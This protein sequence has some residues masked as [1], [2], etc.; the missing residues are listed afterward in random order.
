MQRRIATDDVAGILRRLGAQRYP[1]G[2]VALG[3]TEGRQIKSL[4]TEGEEDV[5]T[6][7]FLTD[8]DDQID[9][10]RVMN[11]QL[12]VFIDDHQ[13]NR[14]RLQVPARQP[15]LLILVGIARAGIFEKPITP[16]DLAVDR[17]AH[18]FRQVPV[19]LA[20][21]RQRTGDMRKA[22]QILCCRLELHVD[23]DHD[24]R[25]RRVRQSYPTA[26]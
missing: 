5:A 26:Q 20:Q 8:V 2:D 4:A 3:F 9:P 13:Q 6:A 10:L 21:V 7:P 1:E 11:E 18:P 17:L 14:N 23:E 12:E 15:H 25:F 16:G 19:V 24:E 22:L